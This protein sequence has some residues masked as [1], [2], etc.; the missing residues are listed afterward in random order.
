[1]C[2]LKCNEDSV[3]LIRRKSDPKLNSCLRLCPSGP[4]SNEIGCPGKQIEQTGSNPQSAESKSRLARYRNIF[5]G[6]EVYNHKGSFFRVGPGSTPQSQELTESLSFAKSRMTTIDSGCVSLR[7]NHSGKWHSPIPVGLLG[8]IVAIFLWG[9]A[10]KL[11]L[12]HPH[13]APTARTQVAK[14]WLET[15]MSYVVPLREIKGLPDVRT[16]LRSLAVQDRPPA[17]LI[18]APGV[19]ND[20]PAKLI[21]PASFPVSSRPPP[22]F[23]L[24]LG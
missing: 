5:G 18:G 14:L 9:T 24:C 16:H 7:S 12:Y 3:A 22:S 10:Y 1:M 21:L 13:P 6:T 17:G 15:R 19:P 2:A 23:S 20:V 8:L 11:S 4:S